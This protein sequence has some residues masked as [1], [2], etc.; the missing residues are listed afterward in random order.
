MYLL[1]NNVL[2]FRFYFFYADDN[3]MLV[4][5]ICLIYPYTPD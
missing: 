3:D 1:I 2:G 4:I 5:Y